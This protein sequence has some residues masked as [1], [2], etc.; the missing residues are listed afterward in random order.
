MFRNESES[1]IGKAKAR[2][3]ANAKSKSRSQS[4]IIAGPSG[5]KNEPTSPST[6]LMELA[7]VQ[8]KD[9]GFFVETLAPKFSMFP[10]IEQRALGYFSTNSTTWFRNFD[11]TD[12]LTSQTGSDEHLLAS[13]S[14]VGLA[15]FSHSIHAPQL[16]LRAR[17]EY[18]TALQLTNT[19]LRSPTEAKKD[20]TLFSVMIL[21]IFETVTGNTERSLTAWA[22]HV[23]GAAALVK[24]R[25]KDQFKTPAGLRMF[26]QVTSNLMLSCIQRTTA[27]P[28]HIIELRKEAEKYMGD[29]PAWKTASIIIDFT[30]FRAAVRDTKIVGPRAV[31]AAALELDRRFQEAFAALPE[32]W[33]Y[34]IVYTDEMPDLVWNGNYHIYKEH[35]MA[36]IWNGM[37]VCRIM[38]HETIRDQ[39]LSASTALTPILTEYEIASQIDNSLSAMLQMRADILASVPHHTPSVFSSKP[40]SLLEGSRAY[41]VLW[42]LYLCGAM[43]VTTEPIRQWVVA[44]LRAIGESVGIRQAFVVADFLSEQKIISTWQTKPDPRLPKDVEMENAFA[45]GNEGRFED[46]MEDE[47]V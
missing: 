17:K 22:E 42:P 11:V 4:P 26:L 2:E 43:D 44:R 12:E 39:L 14:A 47:D 38:L 29:E 46:E 31:I 21:S 8:E 40:V 32:E 27:M 19:A 37:R 25:G 30:I 7:R 3:Q 9:S 24:L 16:M 41:F 45:S 20:S 28:E 15:S 35:W 34:K 36:S 23:N 13:M 5:T 6:E 1:V 10:T 18:V 33:H